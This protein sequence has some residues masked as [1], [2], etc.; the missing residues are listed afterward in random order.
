MRCVL[1]RAITSSALDGLR[2][3]IHRTRFE[4][5]TLSFGSL[6]ADRKITA[7]SRVSGS[8]LRRRHVS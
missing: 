5:S 6:S 3:E 8:S 4:A 1:T 7:A 2:D